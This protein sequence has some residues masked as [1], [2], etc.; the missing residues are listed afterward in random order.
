M[1]DRTRILLITIGA[2]QLSALLLSLAFPPL[3]RHSL[4]IAYTAIAGDPLANPSAFQWTFQVVR[5]LWTT[6]PS[7]LLALVV[8]DYLIQKRPNW[9]RIPA[10]FAIWEL[11][12]LV[13]LIL[14]KQIDARS[15]VTE[16]GFKVFGAP[17]YLQAMRYGDPSRLVAWL[18]CTVPL[19]IAAIRWHLKP[20][21]REFATTEE[22]SAEL[23]RASYFYRVIARDHPGVELWA[24]PDVTEPGELYYW[25]VSQYGDGLARNLER[26][27]VRGRILEHRVNETSGE[28]QWMQVH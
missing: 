25:I 11:L 23:V 19:A 20:V 21:S 14:A 27:R 16:A 3:F 15:L 12:L 1:T 6:A 9:A 10:T 28:E 5:I 2:W 22:Q 24:D 26:V 13:V 7:T 18:I 8:C 17:G 4:V